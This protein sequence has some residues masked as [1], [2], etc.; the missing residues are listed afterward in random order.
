METGTVIYP[1]NHAPQT[2]LNSFWKE[3]R[4]TEVLGPLSAVNGKEPVL[5]RTPPWLMPYLAVLPFSG[6]FSPFP[7]FLLKTSKGRSQKLRQ[8]HGNCPPAD[9]LTRDHTICHPGPL[10]S[11]LTGD[12]YQCWK[13]GVIFQDRCPQESP[14]TPRGGQ[15]SGV[16]PSSP[17]SESPILWFSQLCPSLHFS[18]ILR[19]VAG[20]VCPVMRNCSQSVPTPGRTQEGKH[21]SGSRREALRT[22]RLHELLRW[23]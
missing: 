22:C 23:C 1:I 12:T 4:S 9:C 16:T 6:S 10:L 7:Y 17:R 11:I 15:V 21:L 2:R 18:F 20:Y 3:G 19:L 14:G 5:A 8:C 13:S